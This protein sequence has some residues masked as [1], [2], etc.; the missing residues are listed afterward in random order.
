MKKLLIGLGLA[1]IVGAVAVW[2][3]V[4]VRYEVFALLKV[5]GRQQHVLNRGGEGVDEFQTFKRTQVQLMLSPFVL[6][7]AVSE[8]KIAGLAS[9]KEHNDESYSWL[10][11]QL[12]IDY[13][14]DSEILRISMKGT[15][16]NDLIEIVNMV[17]KK[18]LSEVVQSER[19][20]R[21]ANETELTKHYED[22]QRDLTRQMETLHQMEKVAKVGSAEA[23]QVAK[24][25]AMAK[26]D[27]ALARRARLHMQLDDNAMQ[28]KL[29]EAREEEGARTADADPV[30][31]AHSAASLTAHQLSV[32]KEYL[33]EQLK[34]VQ[35][36]IVEQ[37][38]LMQN[39]ESFS[40]NV[41]SKQAELTRLKN[42]T[43]ELG[44]ELE[45]S[46]IERLAIQRITQ[47]DEAILASP[48]GDA[49][50]KN[51]LA[52]AIGLAG[53]A[54]VFLGAVIPRRRTTW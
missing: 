46:R 11:E 26:L 54:L 47:V 21:V 27:E 9:I 35:N 20:K 15:K 17:V 22:Y 52:L 10:K 49:A 6:R 32:Q 48:R 36:D 24:K 16:P 5:A 14:D 25:L 3:L 40:A 41:A 53:V 19:L 42:I 43:S 45:R 4:P 28:M 12:I 18:Y 50:R 29:L 23:S 31:G 37:A 30:A 33:E 8:P 39:L 34:A 7:R 51:G 44:A 2:W 38:E 13:P 1:I